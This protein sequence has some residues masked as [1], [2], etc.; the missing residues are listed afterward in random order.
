MRRRRIYRRPVSEKRFNGPYDD[1]DACSCG[2]RYTEDSL[3]FVEVEGASL[4]VL[5]RCRLPHGLLHDALFS[6]C[7]Y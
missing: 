1:G 2:S 4:F 5:E 7:N 3:K 6:D